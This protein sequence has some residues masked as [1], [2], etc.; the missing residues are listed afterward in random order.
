MGGAVPASIF[1]NAGVEDIAQAEQ[2]SQM[3]GELNCMCLTPMV[4]GTPEKIRE[5]LEANLI[6]CDGLIMLYGNISPDWVRSQFRN[7]PRLLPKRMKQDPPKP[8]KA[9]ALCKGEPAGRP[10]PGV[11]FPGLKTIDLSA[12][13]GK[14]ELAAWITALTTGGGV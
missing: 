11:N 9:I 2:L 7:L 12:A 5:D 4:E 6:E 10:N 8:L 14:Q 3:L 1:V 13:A